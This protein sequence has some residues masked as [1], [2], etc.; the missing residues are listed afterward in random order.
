MVVHFESIEADLDLLVMVLFAGEDMFDD[1]MV[2]ML[3]KEECDEG[4]YDA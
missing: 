2:W 4:L 1:W 3:K